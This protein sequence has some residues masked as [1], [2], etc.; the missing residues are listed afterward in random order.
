MP[1]TWLIGEYFLSPFSFVD[2]SFLDGCTC[3]PKCSSQLKVVDA[4]KVAC[5]KFYTEDPQISGA[6]I[7]NVVGQVM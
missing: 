4:G 3:F 1:E 2:T 6:T 7:K 5:S